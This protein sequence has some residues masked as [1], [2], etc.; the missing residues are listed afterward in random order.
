MG[1]HSKQAATR[2]FFTSGER[3]K[4]V[5][6]MRCPALQSGAPRCSSGTQPPSL[7]PD[8]AAGAE[9]WQH[10]CS[11]GGRQSATIRSM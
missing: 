11:A 10:I 1:K 3:E 7:E 6:S 8:R 5:S 9:L 2:E 4:A